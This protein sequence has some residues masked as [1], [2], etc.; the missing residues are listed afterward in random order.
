MNV[1]DK[2]KTIKDRKLS[3]SGS[4]FSVFYLTIRFCMQRQ[5]Q[6]DTL[7]THGWQ[8]NQLFIARGRSDDGPRSA[9]CSENY[10]RSRGEPRKM[11]HDCSY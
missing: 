10:S 11:I 6:V 5:H 1:S 8:H 9:F 7:H 3:L 4:G 2:E